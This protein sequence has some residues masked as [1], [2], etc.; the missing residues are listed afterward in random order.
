MTTLKWVEENYSYDEILDAG[1]KTKIIDRE[2]E[3]YDGISLKE[4]QEQLNVPLENIII[5]VS[6]DYVSIYTKEEV[7]LT[8][9]E[10]YKKGRAI[11]RDKEKKRIEKEKAKRKERKELERLKK[12]FEKNGM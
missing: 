2:A 6:Y 3:T 8:E 7:E 12:K 9:L 10:R 4:I 5:S 11:L 1:P